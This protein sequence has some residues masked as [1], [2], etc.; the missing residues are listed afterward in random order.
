MPI[1]QVLEDRSTDSSEKA[2]QPL[3]FETILGWFGKFTPQFKAYLALFQQT[4][5]AKEFDEIAS[6]VFRIF[7]RYLFQLSRLQPGPERA[8]WIHQQIDLEMAKTD[9]SQV[10]CRKGCGACCYL[11]KQITLDEAEILVQQMKSRVLI[12]RKLLRQQ[13]EKINEGQKWGSVNHQKNRC[14]FLGKDQACTVYESRPAVCRKHQVTSPPEE[15]QKN[16]GV[17]TPQPE[18]LPELLASAA[19]SVPDLEYGSLP[20]MIWQ[21]LERQRSLNNN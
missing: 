3:G 2:A 17:I 5:P 18:M 16:D 4:K 9:R 7:R 10:T 12:D 15:C 1:A 21:E 20:T 6:Q 11:E 19:I 13:V 14:I 8:T